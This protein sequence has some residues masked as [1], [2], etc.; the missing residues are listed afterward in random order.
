MT[1]VGD[2]CS[3]VTRYF[4]YRKIWTLKTLKCE[5]D[6]CSDNRKIIWLMFSL[7]GLC[8]FRYMSIEILDEEE[9]CVLVALSCSDGA[10]RSVLLHLW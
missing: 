3:G 5:A 8:V 10:L 9:G 4:Q 2:L 6:M 7:L 1:R